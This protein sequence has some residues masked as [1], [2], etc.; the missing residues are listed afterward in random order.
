MA[1]CDSAVVRWSQ[2]IIVLLSDRMQRGSSRGEKG[3]YG[4][5]IASEPVLFPTL[6]EDPSLH[7]HR[8][9]H[10]G[11]ER[12]VWHPV[13]N[14]NPIEPPQEPKQSRIKGASRPTHGGTHACAHERACVVQM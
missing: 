7:V 12:E 10:T 3:I 4:L 6:D 14:S 1:S 13:A 8:H 11:R 9:A 2:T 5:I